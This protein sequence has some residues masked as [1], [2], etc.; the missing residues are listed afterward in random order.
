MPKLW[1]AACYWGTA[2][3]RIP[4][5]ILLSVA[6]R[7]ISIIAAYLRGLARGARYIKTEKYKSLP[8]YF[9][10]ERDRI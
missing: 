8:P 5:H 6:K 9:D 4:G 7:D 2:V 1:S 10:E 3:F